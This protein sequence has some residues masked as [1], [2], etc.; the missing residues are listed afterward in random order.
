MTDRVNQIPHWPVVRQALT[1][2]WRNKSLWLLGIFVVLAD[3]GGVFETVIKALPAGGEIGGLLGFGGW[4]DRLVPLGDTWRAVATAAHAPGFV[5]LLTTALT[6]V[7]ALAITLVAAAALAVAIGG[8]ASAIGASDEGRKITFADALRR[9]LAKIWPVLTILVMA[10]LIAIV[11]LGLAAGALQWL[12]RSGGVGPAVA[13]LAAFIAF[14]VVAVIV[15]V[16]TVM[17][18]YEITV[19]DRPLREAVVMAWGGLRRHWLAALELAALLLLADVAVYLIALLA[20]MVLAV[21]IIFLVALAAWLKLAWA[22]ALL[23]ALTLALVFAAL[24]VASGFMGVA[25][26]A[27]WNLYWQKISHRTF[28]GHIGEWVRKNILRRA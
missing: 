26:L 1:V 16:I 11:T 21:P 27:A 13:F 19:A 4:F 3:V 10:R 22:V 20:V 25:Q 12:V 15:S 14:G 5:A 2:A 7:L 18:L 24:V 9:G 6:A 8:V 28:V 23:T 17:A